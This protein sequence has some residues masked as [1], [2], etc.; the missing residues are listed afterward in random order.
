MKLKDKLATKLGVDPSTV[1]D[2]DL[3]EEYQCKN[4]YEL[5]VIELLETI[6]ENTRPK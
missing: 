1:T 3:I 2:R 5:R 4:M 6:E